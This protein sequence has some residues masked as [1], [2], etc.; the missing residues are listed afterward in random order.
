[1]TTAK[2]NTKAFTL[3]SYREKANE[4]YGA[5][6]I[7]L[8]DG[9]ST[10]L[11]N[12]MR[13]SEQAQER[14]FEIMAELKDQKTPEEPEEGKW[15]EVGADSDDEI[16][17]EQLKRMRPIMLEF[18]SLVGD[19]NTPLLLDAIRDDLAVLMAVFQDYFAEVGLGEASSSPDA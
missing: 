9:V 2:K 8:G 3:A 15:T 6:T 14:A 16:D 13:I 18:L 11:R 7:D 4:T 5:F 17:F 10:E 19:K 12:P 1:V